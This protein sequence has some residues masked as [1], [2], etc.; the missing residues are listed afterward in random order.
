MLTG[1]KDEVYMKLNLLDDKTLGRLF[2]TNREA[3]KIS[4]DDDFWK[5]RILNIFK[6]NSPRVLKEKR[7]DESYMEFYKSKRFQNYK[8][9]LY[10][11]CTNISKLPHKSRLVIDDLYNSKDGLYKFWTHG[12]YGFDYLILKIVLMKMREE[13]LP[14]QEKLEEILVNKQ[15][16]LK[17]IFH[18]KTLDFTPYEKKYFLKYISHDPGYSVILKEASI[19]QPDLLKKLPKFFSPPEYFKLINFI[20]K[21]FG[22]GNI[23]LDITWDELCSLPYLFTNN[24]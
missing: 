6:E 20:H 12:S 22:N 10:P 24:Y 2:Q 4:L 23:P 11:I 7:E 16:L 3:R 15:D 9:K 18:E 21:G 5:R 1:N 8:E 13:N 14:G 19:N 17:D